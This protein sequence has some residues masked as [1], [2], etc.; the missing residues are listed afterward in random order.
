M[1]D[2]SR[3]PRLAAAV[4]IA[5]ALA[6][7]TP[8][9]AQKDQV[10]APDPKATFTQDASWTGF[11]ARNGG[12]W[13]LDWCPATGTPR[14]IYGTGLELA[15]WRENSLEEARRHAHVLL[16]TEADL[17]R[18]GTSDFRE[19]IGSRMG[20]TWSFV[21]D[22]YF[23]GLPVIG[24]RADVRISM[25]G[26][27]AMFGSTAWQ[28]PADF[29]TTATIDGDTALALA[30]Q[31]L[32]QVP[33]D[34]PQPARV[35][36]PRLV[37]WG[38]VHADRPGTFHLAWE[39]AIS[40]VDRSGEGP[41][42]RSYVD[43]TNGTVLHFESDKHECNFPGCTLGSS[44]SPGE[45]AAPAATPLAAES[46]AGSPEAMAPVVTTVTLRGW[47]RTGN[48]AQSA[49]VD[50]PLPGVEVSVPGIGVV[51]TNAIGQFQINI[52]SP[53]NINI[54]G[55]PGR[56]HLLVQ[57]SNQPTASETVNPG[58]NK[59]I[60]LLT[61][62][63][64]SSEAAH[65]TVSWWIDRTNEFARSILGNTSQLNTASNI[66]VNVNIA[67]TCNASY[68]GNTLNFFAAGGGC[69]NTAFSTVIAHEW[70]HGLDD[71]YGGISQTNGLSEGW[72]DIV[73]LYLVDS[74]ILGSGFSTA[75]QGIRNGNNTRQYPGGSGVHAQGE[76]WMGF[77]W[78][79]RDRLA[80]TL[81][82]RPAA[83]ALSND[84]VIGTVVANAINQED[85][86]LEVFLAD[87]DDGNLANGTP[88]YLD[89]SWAAT[90]HNLPF[91]VVLPNDE[92]SGAIPLVNGVN[93][94]FTNIGSSTST[95]A[96]ACAQGG[97]DVWFSYYVG[98]AGSLVVETCNLADWDTA[99]Q[100]FSGNCGALTSVGCNDDTCSTRSRVT[101]A[102]TPGPYF[103]RVGGFQGALGTF[104]LSVNGPAGVPASAVAYGSG[105]YEASPT[106]Y[107]LFPGNGIDLNLSAM[108][109]V[110]SGTTYTAV[111]LGSFS[112]PLGA[113][114][115]VLTDNGVTTVNLATPFSYSYG[116]TTS[117]E[118]C[119]NG[120][121][122][123]APG[124]GSDSTPTGAEWHA[125]VQPRWGT[126]HDFNPA[127]PGSGKVKF[128]E[129]GWMSYV[130][131][132]GVY[133][134]GTTSGNTWQLQ[135][136]R[137]TGNVAMVW[138]ALVPN[139]GD[140][141][142]G[143]S[144]GQATT[145]RGGI[146]IS[147][148]LPGTIRTFAYDQAPLT[149][150][151]TPPVLGTTMTMTVTNFPPGSSGAVLAIGAFAI[152]PGFELSSEG[153]P[154][155]YAYTSIDGLLGLP[156]IFGSAPYQLAVPNSLPLMGATFAA[157]GA[158][159]VPGIN[160]YGAVTSNG[161][162]FTLGV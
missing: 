116:T 51:T 8:I 16:K 100:V 1:P 46:D 34:A 150:I 101:V 53:V 4:G 140:W 2:S 92:C 158:A 62:G 81:G 95:P 107:E 83:I 109:L 24:G 152:D 143:Y 93:G 131:W 85:A 119:A 74:P 22:Q 47:T 134:A 14:A 26:R 35:A 72:G 98:T 160:F 82:S 111:A 104:S 29:G 103:V 159:V 161:M 36:A 132:S 154:G 79:L 153:V 27:V 86:V 99:I 136:D 61:S 71:R 138:L 151:S 52:A 122:S 63:A 23:R 21:F 25:S 156:L 102:V 87:D 88:N 20:R 50:V 45:M 145:D 117:L 135:F 94:P 60:T 129:V 28:I 112:L 30:W 18:L 162:L 11:L 33:T 115:L 48:D 110:P 44:A 37:I 139:G 70:G 125:S 32:G 130:T 31:K 157:Q 155:C 124:N 13:R 67:S 49:L 55:I 59:T 42:G 84:I 19:T 77:A 76:S 141:L 126:W 91:P 38:D 6:F 123:V 97:N 57:G 3:F 9:V 75:G 54:T 142:V 10:G 149:L 39:C 114:D 73:G 43:A 5:A 65:T 69:S 113:T 147:A 118:V 41:M 80:T 56:H 108:T 133:S 137:S 7:T 128:H 15:D 106:F 148:R 144:A 58:V 89:L 78:K 12:Q 105:C 96:W 64:S 120:F 121:V 127:A 90:Q 17:L 40:N 146:D 68:G 66:A